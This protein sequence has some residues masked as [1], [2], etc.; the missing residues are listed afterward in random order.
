MFIFAFNINKVEVEDGHTLACFPSISS[1]TRALVPSLHLCTNAIVHTGV[2]GT[3]PVLCYGGETKRSCKQ[4]CGKGG[5]GHILPPPRNV[6]LIKRHV[7]DNYFY[8]I[9]ILVLCNQVYR[10]IY[11]DHVQL[12]CSDHVDM[13]AID[14]DEDAGVC[15]LVLQRKSI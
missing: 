8:R 9:D 11:N 4:I 10:N 1:G 15:T 13:C 5:G 3:R 7:I 2:R 6:Q 12:L 14:M